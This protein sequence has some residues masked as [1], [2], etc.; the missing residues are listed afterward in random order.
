MDGQTSFRFSQHLVCS[1]A[2]E[3]VAERLEMRRGVHTNFALWIFNDRLGTI[4]GRR[5]AERCGLGRKPERCG[6]ARSK[7]KSPFKRSPAFGSQR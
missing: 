3:L 1:R 6:M 4:A 7:T 2:C 5:K